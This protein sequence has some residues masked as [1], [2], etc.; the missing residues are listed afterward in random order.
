MQ[1]T[2]LQILR[3]RLIGAVAVL[4]GAA[5][6][7]F[8]AIHL[9][10]G[11][12]VL[13][14][15]GQEGAMSDEAREQVAARYGLDQPLVV[16]FFAYVLQVLTFNLGSSFR[17]GL[18][19]SQMIS[20]RLAPTLELA[21]AA[22]ILAFLIAFLVAVF[23]ANTRGWRKAIGSI[24]ELTAASVPSFWIGILLL[25]VFSFQLGW[26]P[27]FGNEGLRSL[28]LPAVTLAVPVAALLIQVLRKGLEDA[29]DQPFVLAARTRGAHETYVRIAHGLRHALLPAITL[30]GTIFGGLIGGSVIV[31][32]V[33]NRDGIGRVLLLAIEGRDI[34]VV[35]GVLLFAAL[36]FV[37]VNTIIDIAYVL[38][39]PR[40]RVPA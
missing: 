36:A 7:G 35:V 3:R 30:G 37:V 24:T 21:F 32:S 17:S 29:L 6:L 1:R 40:L 34:P 19:V 14:L 16:Q 25:I 23:T 4:I 31:E 11:D 26:F 27:V 39:D 15:V 8:F 13:L 9:T 33:F 18:P 10:P 5:T 22:L 38:I 20:E 28:V 2:L 12:P